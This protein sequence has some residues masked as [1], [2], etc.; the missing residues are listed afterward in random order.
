MNRV[1]NFKNY[2]EFQ[3]YIAREY[4]KKHKVYRYRTVKIDEIDDNK[5][6][7]VCHWFCEENNLV[8][9]YVF[10]LDQ[11]LNLQNGIEYLG[12]TIKVIIDRPLGSHHPQHKELVYPINY[13]YYEDVYAP[14]GEP[15]DVYV[16][17]VY[18]PIS[19]FEGKVIAII[20]RLDDVEDKWVVAPEEFSYTKDDIS[21]ATRFQE[22]FF[23][24]EIIM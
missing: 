7:N 13:G 15:Q 9:D 20:H 16:L 3:A 10:F 5:I 21:E 17:G 8:Q 24:S 6:V 11:E 23:N 12:K 1:K 19:F 4:L 14:D 22:Q 2:D 18:E